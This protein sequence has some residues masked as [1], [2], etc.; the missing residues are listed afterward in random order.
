[1]D[2]TELLQTD[3]FINLGLMM[4]LAGID[5]EIGTR[6]RDPWATKQTYNNNNNNNNIYKLS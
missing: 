2:H 4:T 5:G 1:M 3:I 6:T